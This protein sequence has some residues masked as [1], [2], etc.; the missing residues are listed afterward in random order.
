MNHEHEYQ[1]GDVAFLVDH[2]GNPYK[3]TTVSAVKPYKRGPKVTTA[4]GSEWDPGH[5]GHQWGTRS[6][7]YNTGPCLKPSTEKMEAAFATVYFQRQVR[8]AL[9]HFDELTP[10]Q[11]AT[12]GRAAAEFRRAAKDRE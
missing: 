9:E 2:G 4:D 11:R 10:E 5:Y 7:P 3:R 8:W 1:V 12:L 6:V